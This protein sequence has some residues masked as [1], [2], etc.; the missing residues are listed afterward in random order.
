MTGLH[1][2]RLLAVA[3]DLHEGLMEIAAEFEAN[4][5]DFV[6]RDENGLTGGALPFRRRLLSL[7]SGES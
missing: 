6:E 4:W 7:F 5:N 2:H 3:P 1:S